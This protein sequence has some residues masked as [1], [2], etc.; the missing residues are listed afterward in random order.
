M[1]RK[2]EWWAERIKEFRSDNSLVLSNKL[3]KIQDRALD[4]VIDRIE[5]GEFMY[6]PRTGDIVRVPAKL[7]DV[8]KVA[9]DMIDKKVLLDKISKGTEDKKKEI[10]ADHLVQL[11]KEFAKFANGGKELPESKDLTSVIEG[12]HTE[13][14]ESLGMETK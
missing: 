3:T 13:I 11:A 4:A 2:A 1:W 14:F 7:R 10:T 5:N 9:S 6:D 12:E 8:Q